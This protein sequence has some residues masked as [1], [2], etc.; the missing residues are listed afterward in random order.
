MDSSTDC[1]GQEGL[2]S[3]PIICLERRSSEA[4]LPIRELGHGDSAQPLKKS[5]SSADTGSAKGKVR[6]RRLGEAE[7]NRSV[8]FCLGLLQKQYVP[9]P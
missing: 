2:K 7:K 9:G 1:A 4:L 5:K 6:A 3:L 8:L